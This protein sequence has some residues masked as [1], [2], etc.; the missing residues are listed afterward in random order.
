MPSV[1]ITRTTPIL[2]SPETTGVFVQ[3]VVQEPP[4][5][6]ATTFKLERAG[7]PDGPF[8]T[9]IENIDNY[10]FFDDLRDVPAPPSGTRENV[11]FL[12]LHRNIYYRVTATVNGS[13]NYV[14]APTP[15]GDRLDRRNMLLRRKLQRDISVGFKFNG[16]PVTLLKRRHWG[17]RCSTCFDLLT[18]SVTKPKCEDC[19]GTGYQTGYWAPTQTMGRFTVTAPQTSITN[20]GKTDISQLR[21]YMLDYPVLEPD[22][23]VVHKRQNKRYIVK[24]RTQ[25]ELR[26]VSVHQVLLIN[27]L[28]RDSVEYRIPANLDT[29]PVIY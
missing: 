22:D 6:S 11:N 16:V 20:H 28:P 27:E 7:G 14:S 4:V 1:E 23:I 17:T 24:H 19:F 8:E 5:G 15:L 29:N 18:K 26:T 10:Y 2:R 21:L 13:D 25:T 12:S 9:V 3:W